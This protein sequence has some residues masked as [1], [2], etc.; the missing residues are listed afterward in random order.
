[1][2]RRFRLALLGGSLLLAALLVACGGGGSSG[3]AG[4]VG[5]APVFRDQQE[6]TADYP[7]PGELIIDPSRTYTATMVT[8]KGDID[9]NL[10]ADKVPVT[11]NNFVYL[12]C[13]GFYDNTTF[14]RVIPDF[15]AQGGDPTGTGTGGPGYRFEDEFHPDLKHDKPGILSMANA[16]PNTNGSQ[17]F[18]THV[19][20]PNLDGRHAVFGEV[21]DEASMEVLLSIRER[22]PNSDPNPGDML[23]TV[24]IKQNGQ[25]FCPSS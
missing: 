16:G 11:V 21:A 23:I 12:S 9:L 18:L 19:P 4:E 22:D 5:S 7:A 17:F 10:F 6:L 14:H 2:T 13:A 24:D 1:M 15:M 25:P 20:T 8:A 3:S